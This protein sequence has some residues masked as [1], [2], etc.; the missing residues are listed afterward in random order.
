MTRLVKQRG[1][2]E[3][4]ESAT[5]RG[6][7]GLRRLENIGWELFRWF[8]RSRNP[9]VRN[10]PDY[11]VKRGLDSRFSSQY[12]QDHFCWRL[13]GNGPGLF[14]DIGAYDGVTNSNSFFFERELGWSGLLVEPNPTVYSVLT[15]NRKTS[16]QNIAV[17]NR[18][19]WQE[20]SV[21]SGYAEQLSAL[22][23]Y[24][25]RADRWRM[26]RELARFGGEVSTVRVPEV[27]L[28]DLIDQ[29][30]LYNIDLL[31]VDVEGAEGAVMES[32]DFSKFHARLVLME[33]TY[34]ETWGTRILIM[35]G[36]TPICRL[37]SDVLFLGP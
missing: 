37:G 7:L 9:S 8:G 17:G 2:A 12:G 18:T 20:F 25:S 10:L 21:V 34:G 36:Y 5:V 13:L 35:N 3:L 32:I 27:P 11:G 24:S 31:S 22:K 33:N 28:R 15:R 1:T 23:R 30:S 4:Q 19:G 26:K 29:Y 16:S 6:M 14:I